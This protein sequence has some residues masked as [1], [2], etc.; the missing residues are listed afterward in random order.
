MLDF[1]MLHL[2]GRV[3]DIGCNDG[4]LA[5]QLQ[6]IIRGIDLTGTDINIYNPPFKFKRCSLDKLPF[7]R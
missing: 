5:R 7:W 1:Y 3:L 4:L 2:K 6:S